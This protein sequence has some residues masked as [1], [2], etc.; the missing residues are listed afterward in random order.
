MLAELF[1]SETRAQIF[2]LLF[3]GKAKEFYLREPRESLEKYQINPE[4]SK[5]SC[6]Y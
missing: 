2:R 3:D 6:G 5:T 1:T 4:G